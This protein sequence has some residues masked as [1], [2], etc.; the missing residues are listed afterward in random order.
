MHNFNHER[1]VLAAMSNRYARVCMEDAIKYSR[2]RKTFG[3]RLCDHQ[4]IR[5]K[6]SEMAAKVESCHALLE[7]V[8]YQMKMNMVGTD[9]SINVKNTSSNNK[10]PD[11]YFQPVPDNKIAAMIALAKV[12]ATRTMDVCARES[13]Q[14]LGGASCIRGGQG[15]RIERLYREVRTN[16]IGGG[17]EEILLELAMKQSKL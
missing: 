17:S 5:H 13:S 16:A 2:V 9:S 15:E 7:Q 12:T 14:I 11:N 3:K 4:V 8:A 1:F 10:R 6:I